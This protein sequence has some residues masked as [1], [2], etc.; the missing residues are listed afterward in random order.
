MRTKQLN[1]PQG[2]KWNKSRANKKKLQEINLHIYYTF[3]SLLL[4]SI[5]TTDH[6]AWEKSH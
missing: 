1:K 3:Q 4:Q 6:F 2:I 5:K